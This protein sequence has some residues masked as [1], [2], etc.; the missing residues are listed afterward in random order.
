MR[1]V[2]WHIDGFGV[3]SD[4]TVRDLPPDLTVVIGPNEAG[5]STLLA[6]LRGVLFGFPDRRARE[7]DYPP[8]NGGRPGGRV[9]LTDD[10]GP[11]TV[12]RHRGGRGVR[13]T[14]P[15]GREG[16]AADLARLVGYADAEVFRNLFAF[17]L[18]EL[19]SLHTLDTAAVRD[20]IFT[21]G[22]LG[23]GRS[24]RHAVAALDRRRDQLLRPRATSAAIPRLTAELKAVDS[25]LAEAKRVA[26]DHPRAKAE[27]RRWSEELDRLSHE[28]ADRREAVRRATTLLDLLPDFDDGAEARRQLDS[29]ADVEGLGEDAETQFGRLRGEVASAAAGRDERAAELAAAERRLAGV[30]PDDRLA[31]VGPQTRS[32]YAE[33]SAHA[34][35][36]SRLA[37]AEQSAVELRTRLDE[38]LARL[39]ADWDRA[40]VASFDP[41]IVTSER[42][43]AHETRI[44]R[45]AERRALVDEEFEAAQAEANAR[46]QEARRLADQISR[47]AAVPDLAALDQADGGVR[48]LR[49]TLSDQATA[50]AGAQIAQRAL[51]DLRAAMPGNAAPVLAMPNWLRPALYALAV[52]LGGGAVAAGVAGQPVVA[53]SAAALGIVL[54]LLGL[55]LRPQSMPS[56]GPWAVNNRQRHQE[57]L[58]EAEADVAERLRV[59]AT[60]TEQVRVLATALDL[61][62]APTPVDVEERDALADRQRA[63]RMESDRVAAAAGVARAAAER[64]AQE[65]EI[66]RERT[67]EAHAEEREARAEWVDVKAEHGIPAGL[68]PRAALDVV[69]AMERARGLLRQLEPVEREAEGLH[70]VT[71]ELERRAAEVLARAGVDAEPAGADVVR[72]VTLLHERVTL[73]EAVRRERALYAADRDTARGRLASAQQRTDAA[74]ASFDAFLRAVGASDDDEARSRLSS[75][76]RRVQL[77]ERVRGARDRITARV[78]SGPQADALL[79]ELRG[80]DV[81]GWRARRA[82]AEAD[83]VRLEGQREEAVRRQHDAANLVASIERSG[84]VARAALD[85]EG[86]RQ[87]LAD[88]IRDWRKLT[89]ARALLGETLRRYE[90]ERQPAVMARASALFSSVTESRYE[91]V[92]VV[93]GGLEVLDRSGARFDTADLSRGTAEQLYLC[94]R[95]GLAAEFAA[96]ATPLPLVMDDVLVNF[97]PER[98]RGM[99]VAINA[100]ADEHQVLLF[101]CHPHVVELLVQLRPSTRVIELARRSPTNG[102]LPEVVA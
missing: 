71:G 83:L 15:D 22:V 42:V 96:H 39:G 52:V 19:E 69:G 76:R 91:Q 100:V 23:A 78:G 10:D 1:I 79:D 63:A 97:D 90:S 7:R 31:A 98:A 2:G 29:L 40:R 53:V 5:K 49:A 73:D 26:Q 74:Q 35:R 89:L 56:A 95:F 44:E 4:I 51:T 14:L 36:R 18:T 46:V 92:V 84:E 60:L 70:K 41:S 57:R 8:L 72:A 48:R 67:D 66:L 102:P 101:T 32:L 54:L 37:A 6:F 9:F 55:V 16:S 30:Q 58:S 27:E 59:S 50:I 33:L 34:G 25:Q 75:S 85:R 20:R 21:A 12:E 80:G 93:D 65:L 17:S 64:A 45:A 11:A 94:I 28:I 3:F 24:A 61:P 99:A 13:V 77:S 62:P 68:S 88:A 82:E 47:Y 87:Q 38:E 81:A 43:R 86:L